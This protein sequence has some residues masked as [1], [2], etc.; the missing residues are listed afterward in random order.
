[1]SLQPNMLSVPPS[2]S[3]LIG[4]KLDRVVEHCCDDIAI[5]GGGHGQPLGSLTCAG[6]GRQRGWLPAQAI[7]FILKA[8]ELFGVS[9]EG[10]VLR[11]IT[12]EATMAEDAKTHDNNKGALFK[13]AQKAKDSAPDYRGS[14]NV[15]GV[16][17]WLSGWVNTGRSGEKYMALRVKP[18]DDADTVDDKSGRNNDAFGIG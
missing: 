3:R 1:M 6:C 9:P 18:K 11:T 7:T 8:Q 13:N 14:I 4:I 10:L 5:I 16:E 2:S 12:K 17:H 15:A